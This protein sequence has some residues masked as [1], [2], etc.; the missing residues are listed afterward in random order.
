MGLKVC[1]HRIL[2][3][4]EEVEVVSKGGII[5]V[6]SEYEAKLEKAGIERG[7]IVAIGD[8]CWKAFEIGPHGEHIGKPWAKVGDQVFFSKYGGAYTV[9]PATGEEYL[10]IA[11][12]DVRAVITGENDG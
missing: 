10:I 6:A 3:K 8:T 2:I 4:P 1:G 5:V 11:D 9:D 7:T 12:E